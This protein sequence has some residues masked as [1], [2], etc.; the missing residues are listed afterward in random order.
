MPDQ[1]DELILL[2]ASHQWRRVAMIVA[3]TLDECE[4][5]QINVS[6]D[7]IA[8]HVEGLITEKKLASQGNLSNWR[9]SEVRLT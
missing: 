4:R 6:A 2:A 8:K 3:K 7:E 1:I 5:R 9:H